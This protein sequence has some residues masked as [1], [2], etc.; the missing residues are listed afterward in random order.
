MTN[1]DH[2]FMNLA[3]NISKKNIGS[4]GS[5]PSVGCV[6]VKNGEIIATG[7]TAH[8]GRPHAETVAIKK[9][10]KNS[11]QATLYVTLEPCAHFGKTSPCVDLIINSGIAKVVIAVIDPDL[12]VNGAG[13]KK[14]KEAGITVVIG[15]LEKEARE[16]N[17]GFFAVKTIGR[18][19]ISL[20]L[21][22][23]LDG[24]IATYNFDSKWIT[25]NKAREYAHLL[26]AKNDAILIGANTI[27]KDD[28]MLD[29][30]IA[31]LE[32]YSPKRIIVS[33]NLEIDINSKIIKS[34]KLIPT[35]IATTNSNHQ[36]FLD[37]G[38]K[39]ILCEEDKIRGGIDFTDLVKKI[40]DLEINNL[41]VEGGSMV[42]TRFLQ[43]NLVDK[44][45][46]IRSAAIM[47]NDGVAAIGDLKLEL[48]SQ[49]KKFSKIAIKELGDDIITIYDCDNLSI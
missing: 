18:P 37:L 1:S 36:K 11:V 6:V 16:V 40:A 5:N 49:A 9:A 29:C 13:I 23:S 38:I 30:R 20:K 14:L 46:W 25:S 44:L 4:T 33:D 48:V 35:Y 7:V 28:P 31:G 26:R 19:Y 8:G 3:I 45:I 21:A 17:Q 34:A 41:L 42:A 39:I 15:V 47:G 27:K 32:H 10:G 12:R 2:K 43:E 24:K 22:T